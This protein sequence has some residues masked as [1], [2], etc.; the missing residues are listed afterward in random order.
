MYKLGF[1]P[2]GEEY[3]SLSSTFPSKKGGKSM[4]RKRQSSCQNKCI[5][6]KGGVTKSKRETIKWIQSP[7]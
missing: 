2:G 4:K 1:A 6:Q 7:I 5:P 3:D